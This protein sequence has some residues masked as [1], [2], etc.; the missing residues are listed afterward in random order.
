MSCIRMLL[1]SLVEIGC[2]TVLPFAQN[3]PTANPSDSA[4]ASTLPVAYV[5][6]ANNPSGSTYQIHGYAAGSNGKL[7]PIPGSP[8]A[9]T[10]SYLAV[11]G[12]WLFATNGIDIYSYSVAAN[13]S[14]KQVDALEV[15]PTG[16]LV[17]L[18]LDHSGTSLYTDYFTE[19]NEYLAY[20]IDNANGKL[21][22]IN[23]V[24]G[25]TE[26][27]TVASFIG[28]NE[29]AYSSSCYHFNP[30]IYGLQRSSDGAIT[31]LNDNIPIPAGSPG[32]FYCPWLAAADTTK[33][34]AV[35]MQPHDDSTWQPTG[36]YQLAVYTADRAGDLST[37]SRF[38]TMP[39]VKV[40]IVTEYWPSPSGKLLAVGGRLGLQVFHFNGA[41]PITNYTG[42]LVSQQVDQM[43]WDNAN[44]L[45]A[46]S[47][48]A[49]KLYV[50]TVT[51]T[52]VSQAAGSPYSIA[53]PQNMI[54]LPR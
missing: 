34:V 5:Y 15:E 33:H 13:G 4:A 29:Y 47:R 52:S 32:N 36:P 12:K 28:N 53:H 1:V 40:G 18:F 17:D 19:N 31:M 38:A 30:L 10:A 22:S 23:N 24:M 42:L 46:I 51:P 49:G 27:G 45:Y 2:G 41:N 26:I 54:V 44:H 7:T 8:F 3:A 11:N 14:L 21:T 6:I 39:E 43:F 9:T 16:G 50:F 20:S 25:G 35:A 48:S 37:N